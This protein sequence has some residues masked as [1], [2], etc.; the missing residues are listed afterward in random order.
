MR[1]LEGSIAGDER[2]L[3]DDLREQVA[4]LQRQLR[5]AQ[6]EAS[7]AR[8]DADR[9]LAE[10]R[11][12]LGPLFKALQMV[13]GELDAAG[14]EESAAPQVNSRTAAVWE[15]WKDKLGIGPAKVIDA[16]LLHGEMNTAQLSI[17]TGYHRN[18]V[19]QYVSA[20]NKAGLIT[21]NG[22]RFSLKKL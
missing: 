19:P 14:V 20:C 5:D 3:E 13:F 21:K 8:R 12:Q 22:G 6:R 9:A 2:T 16:L 10:L 1:L 18:T 7:A 17:A 4:D 11:R 15:S